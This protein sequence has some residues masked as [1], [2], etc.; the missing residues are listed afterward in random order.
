MGSVPSQPQP[1]EKNG[2]SVVQGV[3]PQG[4]MSRSR[5]LAA[6]RTPVTPDSRLIHKSQDGF[7]SGGSLMAFVQEYT[8][9]YARQH[10]GPDPKQAVEEYLKGLDHSEPIAEALPTPHSAPKM[11]SDQFMLAVVNFQA[12]VRGYFT[13]KRLYEDMAAERGVFARRPGLDDSDYYSSLAGEWARFDAEEPSFRASVEEDEMDSWAALEE[14]ARQDVVQRKADELQRLREEEMQREVE[15]RVKKRMAEDLR[16]QREEEARRKIEEKAR[17]LQEKIKAQ[18]EELIVQ[19]SHEREQLLLQV[20][21]GF[22]VLSE[23]ASVAYA[24]ALEVFQRRS[25]AEE[26]VARLVSELSESEQFERQTLHRTVQD[27]WEEHERVFKILAL[28][29]SEEKARLSLVEEESSERTAKKEAMTH[30][31]ALLGATLALRAQHN[32][33]KKQLRDLES[34]QRQ[35]LEEEEA[36]LRTAISRSRGERVQEGELFL[37]EGQLRSLLKRDEGLAYRTLLEEMGREMRRLMDDAAQ[38]REA[39]CRHQQEELQTTECQSREFI[40]SVMLFEFDEMDELARLDIE[41]LLSVANLVFVGSEVKRLLRQSFEERVKLLAAEELS[42]QALCEEQVKSRFKELEDLLFDLD[43]QFRSRADDEQGVEFQELEHMASME[44]QVQDKGQYQIVRRSQKPEVQV[45]YEEYFLWS[46]T[47]LNTPVHKPPRGFH[48][49]DEE[50]LER[51]DVHK[52]L[53]DAGLHIDPAKHPLL[54]AQISE[55]HARLSSQP[56]RNAMFCT[57]IADARRTCPSHEPSPPLVELRLDQVR[58]IR[59]ALKTTRE[60]GENLTKYPEVNAFLNGLTAEAERLSLQR[61]NSIA[62]ALDPSA[63]PAKEVAPSP[64]LSGTN[65]SNRSSS[66]W[67][68]NSWITQPRADLHVPQETGEVQRWPTIQAPLLFN[69]REAIAMLNSL[70][71]VEP[72]IMEVPSAPSLPSVP[73]IP[74]VPSGPL[75]HGPTAA[76]PQ[77]RGSTPAAGAGL[78]TSSSPSALKALIRD[79]AALKSDL[80]AQRREPLPPS[81]VVKS[82]ERRDG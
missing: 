42:R 66:V 68:A 79:V 2:D 38:R 14:L 63:E 24:V 70:N 29:C 49:N 64:P 54:C 61:P 17:R 35:L 18:C 1:P 34:E 26:V 75:Q 20:S 69:P 51:L 45:S 77:G 56:Y 82:E 23:E 31:R 41:E 8:E 25:R 46:G 60:G 39:E 6:G 22:T 62:V 33:E 10:V 59:D 13:R 71:L 4:S 16:R 81:A 44:R 72:K 53:A 78:G 5:S 12:C 73:S 48:I 50:I 19:E 58:A 47:P 52:L 21:E 15:E 3:D 32:K 55:D 36:E 27:T 11:S 7:D 37:D 65:R 28:S 40:A 67:S 9:Q 76:T 74:A 57:N 80:A 43:A 30:A